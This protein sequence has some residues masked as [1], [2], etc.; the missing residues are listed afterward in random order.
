MRW[1][2]NTLITGPALALATNQKRYDKLMRHCR[3]PKEKRPG[4]VKEGSNATTTLLE[5]IDGRQICIVSLHTLPKG[6]RR[7]VIYGLLVHEAVHVWQH[8]VEGM[9]ERN[10]S[11]EFEA[12]AIQ[13]IAQELFDEYKRQTK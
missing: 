4:F 8:K 1:L 13:S 3:I 6:T 2:D 10:P 11:N 5:G 12:Y 7:S 9:G